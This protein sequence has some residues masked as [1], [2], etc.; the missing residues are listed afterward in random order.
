MNLTLCKLYMSCQQL[1]S[2]RI[3]RLTLFICLIVCVLVYKFAETSG[4]RVPEYVYPLK[5]HFYIEK[6]GYAGVYLFFLFL[7]Q[8][9]Y[10]LSKNKKNIKIILL[11]IFDFLQ[12]KTPCI[13]HGRVFVMNVETMPLLT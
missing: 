6:L 2:T 12:F 5:P 13:L 4:K 1:R 8:T 10:V 7:L 11:K 9:I 3:L